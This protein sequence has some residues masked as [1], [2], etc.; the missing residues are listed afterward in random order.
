MIK[1]PRLIPEV[2][3]EIKDLVL[4]QCQEIIRSF[5]Q[6]EPFVSCEAFI[7]SKADVQIALDDAFVDQLEKILSPLRKKFNTGVIGKKANSIEDLML[8]DKEELSLQLICDDFTERALNDTQKAL[9]ILTM[10]FEF[11]VGQDLE[12]EDII[13]SSDVLSDVIRTALLKVDADYKLKSEFLRAVLNSLLAV[14]VDLLDDANNAFIARGVLT[15]LNESDGQARYKRKQEKI[16]AQVKRKSLIASLSHNVTYDDDGNP[17]SADMAEVL[18]NLEISER[19][20]E[21]LIETSKSAEYINEEDLLKHIDASYK[22]D[23]LAAESDSGQVKKKLDETRSLTATLVKKA[24]LNNF[25]LSKKNS[26][27]IGMLSML[28]QDL[29]DQNDFSSDIKKLLEGIQVPLLKTAILDKNFFADSDNPA[30][31][32]LNRLSEFGASWQPEKDSDSD[33][34]Y[35]ELAAIVRK[36]NTEF[37]NTYDVF[38]DAIF[39]LESFIKKH[40]KKMVRIEA[41]IVAMEK[42]VARQD[43]AKFE[44]NRH[45]T[46]VFSRYNLAEQLKNFLLDPWKSVLFF[47]HNKYDNSSNIEWKDAIQA[48]LEL[49]RVLNGST[50]NDK[51]KTVYALQEQML[52]IGQTK[53]LVNTELNKIIP[54]VK[55]AEKNS[56]QKNSTEEKTKEIIGIKKK[57]NKSDSRANSFVDEVIEKSRAEGDVE[58]AIVGNVEEGADTEELLV[59]KER[60]IVFL[61]DKLTVGM[62]LNDFSSGEKEKVKIAAYI[63]HTDTYVLV[64][65]KGA[66]HAAFN[67]LEMYENLENDS[68][69]LIESALAFD[70]S[71]ESVIVGLR[72]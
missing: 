32:L 35:A 48:E 71:L 31:L 14:Y 40:Q 8:V 55:V 64:N 47:F 56:N 2:L 45:I 3:T 67:S 9:A 72:H 50:N 61:Q 69:Q 70:R 18:E 1:Q 39:E 21:H 62:W 11:L 30:Q 65:R 66:K 17:A 68:L 42:A 28:F 43:R 16:E 19:K 34:V 5:L 29:F 7:K 24:S 27:S 4:F 58:G 49:V 44:A 12:I 41:R 33:K 15:D 51:K 25:V 6:Q 10:R 37:N 63:K 20:S 46:T 54:F 13:L 52:A 60:L 22:D 36:V 23:I 59:V 57:I 53:S 26:S 38:V